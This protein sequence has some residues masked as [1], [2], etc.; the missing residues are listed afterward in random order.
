MENDSTNN[1]L[2]EME[3]S[4]LTGDFAKSQEI[5][6][7]ARDT[8]SDGMFH[9]NLGTLLAKKGELGAARYNLEKAKKLGFSYPGLEKNLQVTVKKIEGTVGTYRS[10][11]ISEVTSVSLYS[12]MLLSVCLW[13]VVCFLKRANK[14]NWKSFVLFSLLSFSPYLIKSFYIDESYKVAIN[15]KSI[16]IYEGPSEIYSV[17]KEVSEG[18]KLIIGKSH[19]EWLLISWPIELAGWVKRSDIGYL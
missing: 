19:E 12:V 4:Y 3:S 5:L 6:L 11:I 2:K 18:N 8:I 10:S 15:I 16:N 17:I 7:K 9:Y 14:L 13:V 1:L